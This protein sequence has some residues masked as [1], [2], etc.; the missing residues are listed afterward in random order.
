MWNNFHA[1]F[2]VNG[3]GLQQ[4]HWTM[5]QQKWPMRDVETN[6]LQGQ[7]IK[8][9]ESPNFKRFNT[10]L[11]RLVWAQTS[12]LQ[13]PSR[14]VYTKFNHTYIHVYKY[15]ILCVNKYSFI[16][17]KYINHPLGICLKGLH[18][19]ILLDP[20]PSPSLQ[21]QRVLRVVGYPKQIY[22]IREQTLKNTLWKNG[23]KKILVQKRFWGKNGLIW[24]SNLWYYWHL[25]FCNGS[26]C[27]T[28][29]I[30]TLV[31]LRK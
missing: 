9:S 1:K 16:H 27:I 12:F 19:L 2:H 15:T 29:A 23:A 21:D 7:S 30:V 31:I 8:Y 6:W 18:R 10:T 3:E 28:Q 20:K 4:R 26:I 24:I 25:W 11:G 13:L 5:P 17:I 14:C 22:K